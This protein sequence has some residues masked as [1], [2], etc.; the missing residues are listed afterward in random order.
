MDHSAGGIRLQVIGFRKT[1]ALC[2]GIEVLGAS[3][4]ATGYR[5]QVTGI[6]NQPSA[7]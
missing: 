6:S 3:Y 7:F 2:R 4:Q 1:K 5:L